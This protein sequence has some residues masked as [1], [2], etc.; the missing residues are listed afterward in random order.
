MIFKQFTRFCVIGV[1]NTVVDLGLY[2]WLTR[3]WHWHYA[4]ANVV[5]FV[6]ANA[7]SFW[8]NRHWTFAATSGHGYRQYRRF[9]MVSILALLLV[10]ATLVIGVQWLGV[11]DVLSKGVGIGLSIVFSFF[12]HRRWSFRSA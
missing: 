10:E 1:G 3:E 2:L 7:G 12:A 11:S 5:A 6:V 8:L 9:L 4:V